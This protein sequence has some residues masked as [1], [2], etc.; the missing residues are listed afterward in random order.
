MPELLAPLGVAGM[1]LTLDAL[2]TTKKTARLITETLNAH[3][4]LLLK[5]NQLLARAAARLLLKGPDSEFT[6]TTALEDDRGHARIERRT[7]RA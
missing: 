6:Q 5:G 2:H 7:I 3:Y 1:V 4:L